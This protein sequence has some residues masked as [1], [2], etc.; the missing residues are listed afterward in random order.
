MSIAATSLSA[1]QLNMCALYHNNHTGHIW[2]RKTLFAVRNVAGL[3]QPVAVYHC[4]VPVNSSWS[5]LPGFRFRPSST[6]ARS[7]CTFAWW[8]RSRHYHATNITMMMMMMMS[9]AGQSS[10]Q[11]VAFALWC[12]QDLMQG[13]RAEVSRRDW[14]KNGETVS[15]PRPTRGQG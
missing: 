3:Q 8:F 11:S 14:V 2:P 15:S 9:A 7:F 5:Q 1:F 13:T 12:R 10:C 6:V 4:D